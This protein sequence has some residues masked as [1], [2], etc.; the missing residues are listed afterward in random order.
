MM[1]DLPQPFGPTIP[2][3]LLGNL[4]VVVSTKDL[5]PESLILLRRNYDNPVMVEQGRAAMAA[6]TAVV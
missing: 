6:S 4:M 2:I 1:L 3:K 5:K